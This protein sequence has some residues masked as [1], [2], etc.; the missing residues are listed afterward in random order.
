[1]FQNPPHECQGPR[2]SIALKQ[3]DQWHLFHLSLVLI[4]TVVSIV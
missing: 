3:Y 2:I 4:F 1:M